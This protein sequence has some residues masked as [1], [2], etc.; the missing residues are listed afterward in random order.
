MVKKEKRIL[1]RYGMV[2][3][4]ILLLVAAAVVGI[5]KINADDQKRLARDS[6]I[7]TQ[8]GVERAKIECRKEGL[9]NTVCDSV[10]GVFGSFFDHGCTVHAS[11]ADKTIFTAGITIEIKGDPDKPIFSVKQY[12]RG[13]YTPLDTPS[14]TSQ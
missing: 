2:V 14:N 7:A 6:V 5:K 1:L 8:L 3:L 12:Q 9:P 11:A 4:A 10:K 13:S